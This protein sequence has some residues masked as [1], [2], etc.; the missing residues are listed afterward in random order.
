MNKEEGQVCAIVMICD[1]YG[2]WICDT[3]AEVYGHHI[4]R[5][6]MMIESYH[7][8]KQKVY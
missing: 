4:F 2:L 3:L 7:I 8:L 6:C 1:F 5:V